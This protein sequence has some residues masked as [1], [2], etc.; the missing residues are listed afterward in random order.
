MPQATR[1]SRPPCYLGVEGGGTR[2]SVLLVDA[3]GHTLADFQRGPA[4][5]PLLSDRELLWHLRDLAAAL[6][7]QP[8]AVCLGLAGVRTPVEPMVIA[9]TVTY[10]NYFDLP[11]EGRYRMH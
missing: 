8:D 7:R 1:R 6:P 10:G 9:D 3:H 2:T 5:L 4:V 11:G